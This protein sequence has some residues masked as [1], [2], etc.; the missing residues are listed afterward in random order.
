MGFEK[1]IKPPPEGYG[2]F[3]ATKVSSSDLGLED[4]AL[5]E[6]GSEYD[7][8]SKRYTRSCSSEIKQGI[9]ISAWLTFVCILLATYMTTIL[10]KNH[11]SAI[12]DMCF[13]HSTYYSEKSQEEHYLW[14]KTSSNYL[15]NRS[16]GRRY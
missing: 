6:R 14:L 7:L 3:T 2:V 1:A 15:I 12:D 5:L 11:D 8:P 16:C 4:Q 9:F 10:R 13:E